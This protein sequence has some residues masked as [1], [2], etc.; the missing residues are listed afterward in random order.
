MKSTLIAVIRYLADS[1]SWQYFEGWKSLLPEP[2]TAGVPEEGGTVVGGVVEGVDDEVFAFE[3]TKGTDAGFKVDLI[4]FDAAVV[5]RFG[6]G[7]S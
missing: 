5:V 1:D 6:I 2:D 3:G 7:I 4:G